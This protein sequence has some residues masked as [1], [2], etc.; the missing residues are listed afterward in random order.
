MCRV[1]IELGGYLILL[2]L[3]HLAVEFDQLATDRT[4]QVIVMLMVEVMLVSAAPITQPLFSRQPAFTEQFQS[5]IDRRETDRLIVNLDKFIKI[6]SAQVPFRPQ[7]YNQNEFPL[8]GLPETRPPQVLKKYIL[9]LV[10]F[11]HRRQYY[12][13]MFLTADLAQI[14]PTGISCTRANR[15]VPDCNH[16]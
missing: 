8:G 16:E 6:L 9:L 13:G 12:F 7:K 10:K 5:P 4:D 1:K 3:D 11:L 2:V 14:A 15:T